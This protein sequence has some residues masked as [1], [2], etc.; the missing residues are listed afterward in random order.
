MKKC[1]IYEGVFDF[2]L[3]CLLNALIEGREGAGGES[4][5][6][7]GGRLPDVGDGWETWVGVG[8]CICSLNVGV[9]D[10]QEIEVVI[11][12]AFFNKFVDKGVG[13]AIVSLGVGQGKLWGEALNPGGVCKLQTSI[14]G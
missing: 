6:G 7:L 14:D 4:T 11:G 8:C 13:G 3:N 9:L 1:A 10:E 5:G 12:A 2:T